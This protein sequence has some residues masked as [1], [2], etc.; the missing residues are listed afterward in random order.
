MRPKNQNIQRRNVPRSTAPTERHSGQLG[1]YRDVCETCGSNGLPPPRPSPPSPDDVD[2]DAVV[3][4]FTEVDVLEDRVSVC[5]VVCTVV[6]DE[7]EGC[8]VV[9]VVAVAVVCVEEWDRVVEVDDSIEVE[10]EVEVAKVDLGAAVEESALFD[11]EAVKTIDIVVVI[12]ATVVLVVCGSVT[13][14]PSQT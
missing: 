4:V 9:L 6:I 13:S 2:I 11:D 7:V 1:R 8:T 12:G 3:D 10:V 14:F 5:D